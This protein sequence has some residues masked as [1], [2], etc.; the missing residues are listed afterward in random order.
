MDLLNQEV[1]G[2]GE[3][4]MAE[5]GELRKALEIGYQQP[6]TGVGFDALRVESLDATLKTMTYGAQHVKLWSQ[7]P[8]TD[9]YSTVEEY[10]KLLAYGSEGGGFVQSGA[11]PEEEDSTY[12]RADQKVKYLGT[13]RSVHHPATLVRT[14][15]AD[16][17]ATET[18]NGALWLMGKAN[19]GLYYGD[20]DAVPLEWNGL[21]KQIIDGDGIVIDLKGEP[22][23][24]TD[25]E[26]A[27]QQVTEN[28]GI[29]GK[30]FTNSKVFTDFSSTYHQ[31]QRWNA[32]GG[33]AGVAGTPLTGWNTQ[34]GS[35]GFES[36]VFVKRGSGAPGSATSPKAPNAPT[37][38]LGAPGAA[39]GSVFETAD[40]GNYR[41]QVTA[42]N[43][44][45]ESAPSAISAATAIA[46]GD[47]VA[48]TITD[49]GGSFPATAYKIYRTSKGGTTATYTHKVQARAKVGGSYQ[50][51]TT[52]TDLNEWRP[53]C[54]TGLLLDMSPQSLTFRQLAPML[55][56][57][58]AV[59]SPAIRWMQLLYG[60]PIVFA[61]K[62]NVVF[63]NIGVAS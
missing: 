15:P 48:L 8:K 51:T 7:V 4:S 44:F 61:P 30:I 49:G 47:G 37:L 24:S 60:T 59:I 21:T 23:S 28:F 31:Y 5:L 55:K 16:L 32:P 20:S 40:A 50:A 56:M 27:A 38:A 57:N 29:P 45:G 10:N 2:F 43:Q 39:A 1:D 3:T 42:I 53:G 46:A 41:W 63:K 62:K 54:F 19:H 17:I 9:A 22:L 18:Q 12:E 52:Y 35:V 25:I 6:T 34:V 33:A 58:L 36:D 14:V 26:N 11:L 13:T